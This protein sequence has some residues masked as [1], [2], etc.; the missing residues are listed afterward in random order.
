MHC[1][2]PRPFADGDLGLSRKRLHTK[3]AFSDANSAPPCLHLA[4]IGL[5]ESPVSRSVPINQMV[6][7]PFVSEQFVEREERPELAPRTANLC[8]SYSQ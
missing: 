4:S 2:N 6:S 5:A 1:V 8:G 3:P 7:D